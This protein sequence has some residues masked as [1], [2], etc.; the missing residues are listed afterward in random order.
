MCFQ[1][2]QSQEAVKLEHRFKARATGE[3]KG[4]F[5]AFT[6][7][8]TPV[9]T[10]EQ[11]AIIQDLHWGL[12]P[13][14]SNSPDIRA[15]TL[16]ARRE[17]LHEKPAFKSQLN[18]RC[19]VIVDAF[20]EWQWLDAKGKAKQQFQLSWPGDEAFALAGLWSRW[21]NPADGS[22][23]DSYTIITTQANEQM[24]RIHN[25][26]KRMPLILGPHQEKDWLAGAA[27]DEFAAN[28]FPLIENCINPHPQ[29]RLF[30]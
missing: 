17:S 25:S 4:V 18:W 19:L 24:A 6:Y 27:L 16:N 28:S 30:D 8:Q 1:H 3:H 13:G 2:K 7:P 23:R 12:I 10:H 29:G 5:S 11:P 9:I 21:V 14:W 20:F 26:K 15:Y 22:T